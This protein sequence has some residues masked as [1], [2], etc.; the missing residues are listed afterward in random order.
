MATR[1]GRKPIPV[2]SGVQVSID[3]Q[4]VK[5]KG[6]KGELSHLVHKAVTVAVVD[7]IINV[8]ANDD[9]RALQGTTRAVL[10]NLVEGVTKQFSKKLLLVGVGYRAAAGK[11]ADGCSKLDLTLGFSH[12]V[13]Y[14]APEGVTLNCPTQ[15]EIEIIGC[16]KVKVG[17]T[18]A[19]IRKYREPE[20]YK[21]KGIRYSDEV[22]I[23][24]ETKKK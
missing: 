6:P 19:E 14:V 21:G 10:N 9:D 8:S 22:I 16:D 3:A 15:T 7:N 4:L 1:V 11:T 18:A 24:K 13:V 23:I 17:Q 5:I 20:P 2:P 12:P